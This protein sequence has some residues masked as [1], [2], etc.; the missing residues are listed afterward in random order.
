[1]ASIYDLKPAF[2]NLLRPVCRGLVGA[3]M[4]ANQVTVAAM[5]LSYT[6]GLMIWLFPVARWPLLADPSL[7]PK[8]CPP[9]RCRSS[10]RPSPSMWPV[11]QV[12]L[13]QA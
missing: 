9:R 8:R 1:M 12:A 7:T 6:A 13:S 2:Q 4:T 3:G 11:P 10:G 5:V